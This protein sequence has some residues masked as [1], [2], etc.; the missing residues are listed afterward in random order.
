MPPVEVMEQRYPLIFDEFMLHEGS[1]GAGEYRGGFGVRYT[2]RMRDGSGKA[3]FMMDHGKFGPP[4]VLGGE[5]GGTNRIRVHRGNS[6]YEPAH[7]SKDQSVSVEAGDYVTVCSPGGGGYG[8]PFA[9]PADLVASD[10]RYGY[11]APDEARARFGV[12]LT[13]DLE[14]DEPATARLRAAAR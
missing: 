4:G 12:A 3:S 14:V 5:D 13:A 6:V 2:L 1:G 10:V 11:Y 7:V 9:R 8:N